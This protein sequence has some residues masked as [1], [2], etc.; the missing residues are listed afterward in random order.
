[1]WLA[2]IFNFFANNRIAQ[3]L[4]AGLGILVFLKGNSWNERRKGRAQ[5]RKEAV[6]AINE[7]NEREVERIEQEL[8]AVSDALDALDDNSLRDAAY[9]SDYNRRARG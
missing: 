7:A 8:D 3:G 4:A 2:P 9:S 1:M 6:D 5:G